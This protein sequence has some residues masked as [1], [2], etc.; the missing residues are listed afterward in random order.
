MDISFIIP[1]LNCSNFIEHTIN[2]LQKKLKKN[3]IFNYELILIDDGSTDNTS[4]IL[5]K[6]SSKKIRILKNS[7]NIGKSASLLRGIKVSK[8]SKIV[9][10]DCDLPY[11]KYLGLVLKKLNK[12]EFIYINR[13]SKKSKLIGKNLNLYQISRF[14]IG[15]II[16][17]VFLK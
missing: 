6:L 4:K 2:K 14:L 8:K 7:K 3:N 17:L 5:K 12:N 15:R 13:K 16:C 10:I 9:M 1:C 11:F